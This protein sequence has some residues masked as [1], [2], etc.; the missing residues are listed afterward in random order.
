MA[1]AG[2]TARA[3]GFGP[4]RSVIAAVVGRA[5]GRAEAQ[6]ARGVRFFALA[7]LGSV[8]AATNGSKSARCFCG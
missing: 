1:R 7:G 8:G 2:A 5:V 6:R 4:L 3:M